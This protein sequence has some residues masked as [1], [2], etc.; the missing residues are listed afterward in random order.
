MIEI[1][2]APKLPIILDKAN[3]GSLVGGGV[4]D[5]IALGPRRYDQKGQTRT[6]SAAAQISS[7]RSYSAV[8]SAVQQA[9]TVFPS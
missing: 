7:R 4:I 1:I 6:I 5:K 9:V 8:D 3:D 2:D